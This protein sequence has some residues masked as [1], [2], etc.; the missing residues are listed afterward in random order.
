LPLSDVKE[1]HSHS[2]FISKEVIISCISGETRDSPVKKYGKKIKFKVFLNFI[3]HVTLL[4]SFS[5]N[6]SYISEKIPN[7]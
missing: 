6:D 4:S 3:D 5:W 2:S 1:I 7:S